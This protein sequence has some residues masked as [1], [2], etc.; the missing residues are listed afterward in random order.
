LRLNLKEVLKLTGLKKVT[1]YHKITYLGLFPKQVC[2]GRWDKAEVMEWLHYRSSE[3]YLVHKK[4]YTYLKIYMRD[5][6]FLEL[7]NQEKFIPNKWGFFKKSELDQW[8]ESMLNSGYARIVDLY[9]FLKFP[10]SMHF[11]SKNLKI[12]SMHSPAIYGLWLLGDFDH[13][14]ASQKRFENEFISSSEV[15]ELCGVSRQRVFQRMEKD[16]PKQV[17]RGYWLRREVEEWLDRYNS[18][19]KSV[20]KIKSK[21]ETMGIEKQRINREEVMQLAGIRHTTLHKKIREGLLPKQISGIGKTSLWLRSEVEKAIT[22]GKKTKV[23]TKPKSKTKTKTKSK[24]APNHMQG[25]SFKDTVSKHRDDVYTTGE[26]SKMLGASIS[27]LYRKKGFPKQCG[28]GIWKKCDIDAWVE[29]REKTK[30][31]KSKS[32]K[33][34]VKVDKKAN[35]NIT[36]SVRPPI[37]STKPVGVSSIRDKITNLC[38]SLEDSNAKIVE[39]TK[40]NQILKDR[41]SKSQENTQVIDKE[42]LNKHNAKILKSKQSEIDDLQEKCDIL[43]KTLKAKELAFGGIQLKYSKLEKEMG[44]YLEAATQPNTVINNSDAS[45]EDSL[46]RG[47]AWLLTKLVERG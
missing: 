20:S 2:T 6:S 26:V 45:G 39:L 3:E 19:N 27:G 46:S 25:V 41:L 17:R 8:L 32:I 12:R 35:Q 21:G 7:S 22:A 16:F 28:W 24:P 42:A 14:L 33:K 44:E 43:E 4:I 40:E 30:V 13:Y 47:I 1:L 9:D 11:S 38:S 10:K 31:K 34:A 18:K 29:S 15:Y 23:K 37:S 36:V 5:V